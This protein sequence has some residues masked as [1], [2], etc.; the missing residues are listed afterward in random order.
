MKQENRKP[1]KS[2]TQP[3]GKTSV[4]A[5]SRTRL[6]KD[7]P[8]AQIMQLLD[9]HYPQADC[10]LEHRTP[11]QLVAATI[12]SAQ[13]TDVMVNQV[14]PELFRRAPDAES[15]LQLS[16]PELE[17]IIHRTGFFSN[18]A[19]NIL[20]MAKGIVE[21]FHGEVPQT[22]EELLSLPGV[23][24]KTASVVLGVAF[25][26][27]EGIVV[28]TH[29]GRLSQRLGWTKESDPVKIERDLIK[30]IPHEKWIELSH[31]LIYH[32][33]GLCNARQPHCGD[34][35]LQKLCPSANLL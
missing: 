28:D 21:R 20:G 30:L 9:L 3:H 35:F 12:L 15:M 2:N 22:M 16:Q 8:V 1:T 10:A 25:H 7:V 13:C 27:A 29:V 24:R 4:S 33:R 17:R 31:Q 19:K 32:G 18:K 23:G 6:S 14:T 5:S 26:K 11:F 34:C